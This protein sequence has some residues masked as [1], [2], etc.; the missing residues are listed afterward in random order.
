GCSTQGPLAVRFG[1]EIDEQM[2]AE[3]PRRS[4]SVLLLADAAFWTDKQRVSRIPIAR[5]EK[6][7]IIGPGAAAMAGSMLS[8]IFDEVVPARHLDRV[9]NL[10]RFDFVIRLVQESFDSR[11]LFLPLLAN[12]RF[13]VGLGAEVFR[14]D[15]GSPG[16]LDELGKVDAVGSESFWLLS[17][18][19]TNPLETDDR[20]L[21]KGARALNAAIQESLFA[22]MDKL[23]ELPELSDIE[24]ERRQ[25]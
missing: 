16:K 6:T 2:L 1:R 14:P 22:L 3:L 19:P 17:I 15:A 24:S 13:R 25:W 5:R 11:A 10:E 18:A 21:K 20:V 8:R 9:E 7:F 12:H 23:L 4:G